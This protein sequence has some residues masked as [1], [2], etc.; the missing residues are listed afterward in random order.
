MASTALHRLGSARINWLDLVSWEAK[1]LK[2][3]VMEEVKGVPPFMKG[4]LHS[5]INKVLTGQPQ[6]FARARVCS[7]HSHSNS[8]VE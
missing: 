7:P 8:T 3:L 2:R 6:N 1:M 5:F 4:M